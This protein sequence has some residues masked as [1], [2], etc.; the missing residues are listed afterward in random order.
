MDGNMSASSCR[1]T[2]CILTVGVIMVHALQPVVGP[3]MVYHSSPS[4]KCSE[5]HSE[6]DREEVRTTTTFAK[7]RRFWMHLLANSFAASLGTS[8]LTPAS[9]VADTT[10]NDGTSTRTEIRA[11]IQASLETLQKL[12]QNWE[13]AVIDC[14]YADVPRELLETQNKALLLEKASVNALFDK[15]ASVISCKTVVTT[16]R[17]YLGRTGIGPVAH[18]N[19]DLFRAFRQAIDDE[20]IPA[21]DLESLRQ[22]IEDVQQFLAR[23]DSLS[24]SARRDATAFNNF[25]PSLASQVVAESESNLQQCKSAIESAIILL[26][27]IL[28]LLPQ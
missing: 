7:S 8:L 13:R 2:T 4:S 25:D 12:T 3:P 24:Y 18:L 22:S 6:M 15:S 28:Q 19:Q 27:R 14:T 26:Q 10:T 21:D 9:A 11:P 5:H 23:A 1:R 16:V 17:D 20:S